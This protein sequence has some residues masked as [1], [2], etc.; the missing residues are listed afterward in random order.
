MQAAHTRESSVLDRLGVDAPARRLADTADHVHVIGVSRCD[1]EEDTL[2]IKLRIDAGY[3]INAN[4]ASFDYLV[5]TSVTFVGENPVRIE[6]PPPVFFKPRFADEAIAVYEGSVAIAATFGEGALDRNRALR[7][8]ITAQACTD[9]T[10][11]PPADLP[12]LAP[13][14]VARSRAQ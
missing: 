1:T 5:P 11:L 8:T 9:Q 12:A 7:V 10:C 14:P 13:Q 4:P 2:L 3:H 6:Y